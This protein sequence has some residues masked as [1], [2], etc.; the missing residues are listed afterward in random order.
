MAKVKEVLVRVECRG[1]VWYE[2][3]QISLAKLD[4]TMG[5]THDRENILQEGS[6]GVRRIAGRQ[7]SEASLR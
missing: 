1:Q 7:D 5:K 3:Q 2:V 4:V 6:K